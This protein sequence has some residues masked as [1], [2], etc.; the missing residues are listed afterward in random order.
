MNESKQMERTSALLNMWLSII[1][2]CTMEQMPVFCRVSAVRSI[3][4]AKVL[5]WSVD[6]GIAV[7]RGHSGPKVEKKV[8]GLVIQAIHN[9]EFACR[10]WL[11][12]LKLM[13]VFNMSRLL[14]ILHNKSYYA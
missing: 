1:E 5:I 14:N 4:M 8:N 13:Q 7:L 3:R 9:G 10:L 6:Y 12:I 2:H 11:V